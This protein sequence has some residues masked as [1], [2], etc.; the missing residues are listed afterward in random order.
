MDIAT[1]PGP[2]PIRFLDYLLNAIL[3]F[4]GSIMVVL[5]FTNVVTHIFNKEIIGFP[6]LLNTHFSKHSR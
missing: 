6:C 5:V 1:L 3:I 2:A 4:G